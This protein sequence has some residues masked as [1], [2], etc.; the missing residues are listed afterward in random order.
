MY[1][2]LRMLEKII[3]TETRSKS[4]EELAE[5][6]KKQQRPDVLAAAYQKVFPWIVKQKQQYV[7]FSE[8]E[9]GSIALEKLDTCLQ[10]YNQKY[11]FITFFT[12]VLHNAIRTE[13]ESM[14][15]QKRKAN[16]FPT[17]WELLL[18][19]GL[20]LIDNQT[21]YTYI[22]LL[23]KCLNLTKDEYA[24]C[25]ATIQSAHVSNLATQAYLGWDAKKLRSVRKSLQSKLHFLL[26]A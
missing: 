21:E 26:T 11:K 20:D 12:N 24:F 15:T 10:C 16:I 17:S 23:L 1:E 6:Y 8:Q 5:M 14:S 13:I 3:T 7:I 19:K 4:L 25:E 18:E 9:M 2:T 22:E